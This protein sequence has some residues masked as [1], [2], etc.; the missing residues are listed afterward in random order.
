[1]LRE[2]PRD[3]AFAG[4]DRARLDHGE[5]EKGG[6][7]KCYGTT[8]SSRQPADPALSRYNFPTGC[9]HDIRL[10]ASVKSTN[11]LPALTLGLSAFN[12]LQRATA[13]QYD[14]LQLDV[15]KY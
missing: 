10:P 2:E 3:V 9:Q 11:R 15:H 7:M 1:M 6:Q 14:N 12:V 8:A 5:V 4:T 13:E